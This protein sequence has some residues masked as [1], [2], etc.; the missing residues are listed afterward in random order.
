MSK[1]AV[2]GAMS[3]GAVTGA[4]SE[5][6]VSEPDVVLFPHTC[7]G[8]APGRHSRPRARTRADGSPE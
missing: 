7:V 8:V 3:E 1:G 6:A 4:V 5:G 2:T